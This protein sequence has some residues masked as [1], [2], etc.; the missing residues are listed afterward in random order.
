KDFI[1]PYKTND[2]IDLDKELNTPQKDISFTE[3]WLDSMAEA[4]DNAIKWI[5]KAVKTAKEKARLKALNNQKDLIAAKIKLEKSGVKDTHFMY[6]RSGGK[7][8]SNLVTEYN[9]YEL[10]EAT[11]EFFK[12]I[13]G[14]SESEIKLIRKKWNK[15]N[16]KKVGKEYLPAD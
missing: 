2:K 16:T 6:E 7:L 11:N 4:S 3:R 9:Q 13:E 10:R 15:E 5:D 1:A 14:K 8:T 12:S